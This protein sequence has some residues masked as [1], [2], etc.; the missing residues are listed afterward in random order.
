MSDASKVTVSRQTVCDDPAVR[1]IQLVAIVLTHC[2]AYLWPNQAEKQK[3]AAVTVKALHRSLPAKYREEVVHRHGRVTDL[4][5]RAHTCDTHGTVDM[6]LSTTSRDES[7][8]A[9]R[10]TTSAASRPMPHGHDGIPAVEEVGAVS[11]DAKGQLSDDESL[12]L[13][14]SRISGGSTNELF[15][16]YDAA[17]ATHSVVFRIF[18]KET[19]RIVARESEFF[20]QSLYLRT[21]VHGYN[22]MV[23]EYL[24]ELTTLPL[25][26]MY[27]EAPAIADALAEFHVRATQAARMDCDDPLFTPS[28]ISMSMSDSERTMSLTSIQ[29][30]MGKHEHHD[31]SDEEETWRHKCRYDREGNFVIHALTN[32]V[33][34]VNSDEII[35]V[36][37]CAQREDYVQIAQAMARESAIVL[38]QIDELLHRSATVSRMTT[39]SHA[40]ATSGTIRREGHHTDSGKGHRSSHHHPQEE[41]EKGRAMKGRCCCR[42]T[43]SCVAQGGGIGREGSG[44]HRSSSAIT[45]GLAEAVCHNDLLS[46]NIM[47]NPDTKVMKIIDFD[48]TRRSYL[49]FDVGNH[50]NEYGGMGC[51][52][53]T[54]FLLEHMRYFVTLYRAAMRRHLSE[55]HAR[56]RAA[57]RAGSPSESHQDE[58]SFASSLEEEACA[59][60]AAMHCES[61]VI[62]EYERA[63]FW[64][65]SEEEE[66][67]V[68]EVWTQLSMFFTVV[69]HLAWALWALVEVAVSQLD[70]DYLEYAHLRFDRYEQ[71]KK[72]FTEGLFAPAS[73]TRQAD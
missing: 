62:I 57:Q 73:K 14:I 25:P 55:A 23:Y 29:H 2:A 60:D 69:S 21:F 20:Y 3:A 42:A 12:P 36:V 11:K 51:E 47:Y 8:D 1:R 34:Q 49:L 45:T 17:D 46:G 27:T 15:H 5:K 44:S 22:F 66:R 48:F 52:Y 67:A 63:V 54:R 16:V 64:T 65:D 31:G 40:T 56:R 61:E 26:A 50:F 43:G 9:H 13:R 38:S 6:S 41:E 71:T 37:P 32:W 18:G 7:D 53:D 19:D 39:S 35:N 68:V 33:H 10:S 24:S 72:A 70:V 4:P 59:H 28:D 30:Y 58:D